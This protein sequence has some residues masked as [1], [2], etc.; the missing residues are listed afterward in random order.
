MSPGS[1][2]CRRP[3]VSPRRP[4]DLTEAI[5]T[6][7]G[8]LCAEVLAPLQRSGDLHPARL[9]N[10]VV[11]TSPGFAEG[12]AAIRDGGWVGMSAPVG[13]RRHG[14]AADAGDLRQRDDVGGLP[15]RCS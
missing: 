12:Y 11:R 8:R 6:E 2:R 9:E 1:A 15:V 4:P 13:G 5:L 7:A 10:G 3:T 14:P